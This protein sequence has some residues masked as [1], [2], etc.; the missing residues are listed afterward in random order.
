MG[1]AE[2]E[3]RTLF[4]VLDPSACLIRPRY[5]GIFH[6]MRNFHAPLPESTYVKLKHESKRLGRPATE[7]AR[8]AIESWLRKQERLALS[9]A[10]SQYAGSRAG[11]RDDLDTD[12]EQAG[13]Q[14]LAGMEEE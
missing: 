3:Q 5:H 14:V 6:G 8:V 11:T 10:I 9:A 4:T 13:L 7:I 12:L 2:H 1:T